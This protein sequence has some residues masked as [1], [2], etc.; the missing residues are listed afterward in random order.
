MLKLLRSSARL[1]GDGLVLGSAVT[2]KMAPAAVAT[3]VSRRNIH[4]I[5]AEL[6]DISDAQDPDFF[7]MVEYFYHKGWQVCHFVSL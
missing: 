1:I 5:P 2:A 7:K 6:A 4:E 3:L